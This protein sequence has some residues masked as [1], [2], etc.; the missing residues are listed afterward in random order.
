MT[1]GGS[2]T[3]PDLAKFWTSFIKQTL[4]IKNVFRRLVSGLWRRHKL[5]ETCFHS[6]K[7]LINTNGQLH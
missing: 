7:P 2:K 5:S 1:V 6:L 3:R 4:Q